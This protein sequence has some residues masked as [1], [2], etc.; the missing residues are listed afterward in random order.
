MCDFG[1]AGVGGKGRRKNPSPKSSTVPSC[2]THTPSERTAAPPFKAR[3][4]ALASLLLR[5]LGRIEGHS[6]L[7]CPTSAHA[8]VPKF[9]HVP[10][11][12]PTVFQHIPNRDVSVRTL[13]W[14]LTLLGGRMYEQCEPSECHDMFIEFGVPRALWLGHIGSAD[15]VRCF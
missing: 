12:S 11:P 3:F 1:R 2:S 9:S 14:W 8:S 7:R 13:L 6:L 5:G 4:L 15:E 10:G